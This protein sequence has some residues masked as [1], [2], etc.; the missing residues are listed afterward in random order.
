MATY[1]TALLLDALIAGR[2]PSFAEQTDGSSHTGDPATTGAPA[3]A[4]AGVGLVETGDTNG[5]IR[6]LV[7]IQ[8]R[9]DPSKRTAHV[10]PVNYVAGETYT[11]TIGGNA[12]AVVGGGTWAATVAL[13]IAALP[14]VPAAAALVTFAA[15]NTSDGGGAGTVDILVV[16]WKAEAATSIAATATGAATVRCVADPESCDARIYLY[17][18]GAARDTVTLMP[19]GWALEGTIT[20]ITYRNLVR[21]ILTAG[22][23]RAYVEIYAVAGAAGDG[24]MVIYQDIPL[25][26]FGRTQTES[27]GLRAFWGPCVN[28]G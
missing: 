4:G 11:V 8:L 17:R 1:E 19:T 22:C 9:M 24:G 3:T 23:V 28:E 25:T 15:A 10:Y 6:A 5:A 14:G 27:A 26:T 13:L 18:G 21:S 12:V 16:R 7:G 20:G 2:V